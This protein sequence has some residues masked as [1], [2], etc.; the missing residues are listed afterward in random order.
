M[1]SKKYNSE[2]EFLKDYD[3]SQFDLL[4]VTTD[5]L[6]FSV[7][8]YKS[9]NYRKL[10]EKKFSVLLVKRDD[11]PYKDKWCLPGGFVRIDEDLED[12]PNRILYDEANI[13]DIYLEQLYTYGSVDRDPRMRVVSTSYM[14]LIDKNRLSQTVKEN[15]SWFDVL[16]LEDEKTI[17]VTLDNGVKTIKYVIR[18][19][20]KEHT[21]DRYKYEVV[22]NDDLAFDH[23]LVITAGVERLKN[24]LEYTDIVFNMMPEYFTLGE[25]QQVY[26]VILGK[27]LLDPA[28]R[29]IIK[30]KVE[31]TDKT[32]VTGGHRP[33]Y[34]FRYKKDETK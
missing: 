5:I 16:F 31:K 20:L 30:N 34:L 27:K 26:E 21:T 32:V 7:S 3:S 24:K 2:E 14:A 23:A 19:I 11:Y 15:A 8:D 10:S 12:A 18:K 6:I 17:H 9:N 13:K 1:E 28:F 25:L 29:R 4:S 33:S 22:E